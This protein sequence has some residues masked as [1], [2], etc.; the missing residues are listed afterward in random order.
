MTTT[1]TKTPAAQRSR[2]SRAKATG[3]KQAV[4][5]I[6]DG[7]AEDTKAAEAR[8]A[9]AANSIDRAAAEQA[10]VKAWEK[11]GKQGPKPATPHYDAMTASQPTTRKAPKE[12]KASTRSQ[13]G[14]RGQ[15]ARA[16]AKGG[17]RGP[18]RK[19]TEEELLAHITKV[20]KDHPESSAADEIEWAYWVE[21]MAIGRYRFQEAWDKVAP[22]VPGSAPAAKPKA[23]EPKVEETKPKAEPK[24][25]VKAPPAKAKTA[26]QR[27]QAAVKADVKP[28][29][30]AKR[31]A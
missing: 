19:V 23:T 26:G 11:A 1:T 21:G 2:A 28:R 16:V 6:T 7:T 29:P 14:E 8:D 25:A 22:S 24:A 20:R 3:N 10:A 9:L 5:A 27:E 13:R 12:P 18:G 31:A 30:K 15:Q 17:K 4:A